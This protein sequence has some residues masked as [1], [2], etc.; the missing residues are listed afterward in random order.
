MESQVRVVLNPGT[1]AWFPAWSPG[2]RES[3]LEFPP[4]RSANP[5]WLLSAQKRG[6]PAQ[7]VSLENLARARTG[8]ARSQ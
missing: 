4:L 5:R 2:T 8:G 6:L 1:A 7:N 3:G